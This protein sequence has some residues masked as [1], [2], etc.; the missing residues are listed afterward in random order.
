MSDRPDYRALGYT[1][2]RDTGMA[3][4]GFAKRKPDGL[5]VVDGRWDITSVHKDAPWD[6]AEFVI[7]KRNEC[8]T[9]REAEIRTEQ[10]GLAREA[11]LLGC[12]LAAFRGLALTHAAIARK[13][14]ICERIAEIKSRLDALAI[15]LVSARKVAVA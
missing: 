1:P 5:H 10:L 11:L 8:N 7:A 9:R 2:I 15:E 3:V 14:Q 4:I 6:V 12:E 13:R